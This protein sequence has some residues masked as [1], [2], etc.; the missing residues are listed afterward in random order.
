[1]E[2]Y[3]FGKPPPRIRVDG[4]VNIADI[5][6]VDLRFDIKGDQ[7]RWA[8]F[9]LPA[10]AAQLHWTNDTLRITGVE[11]DFYSGKLVGGAWFDFSDARGTNTAFGFDATVKDVDLNALLVD[12]M[13]KS[14]KT[15]GILSGRMVVTN[16][17]TADLKS[18]NGWGHSQLRDGLLWD[19]PIFGF[20]SKPLNTIVPGLGNNRANAATNTFV[21]TNSVFHTE[22]LTIFTGP[23]RLMYRGT[24]DFE[25]RVDARVEAELL[26]DSP[27]IG[28]VVSTVLTP[29]S[30][31]FEFKV[32]GTLAEPNPEPSWFLPKLMFLPLSPFRTLEDLFRFVTPP[33]KPVTPPV[34]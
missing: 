32:D 30:K 31:I 2:P 13:S 19:A 34:P 10:V 17:T 5:S 11:G 7:F 1:M 22:D 26:K 16:A 18:W 20:L 6:Q 21:L 33:P 9:Q 29:L 14:N 15:E 12:T 4:S 24:V 27:V 3:Q 8:A 23:A 28:G 25:T